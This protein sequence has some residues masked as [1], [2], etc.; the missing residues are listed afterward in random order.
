[1]SLTDRLPLLFLLAWTGLASTG[2]AQDCVDYGGYFPDPAP[3]V[4]GVDTPESALGMA[5]SGSL[6]FVACGAAGLQVIDLSDPGS[7]QV[8]GA[9]GTPGTAHAVAVLEQHAYVADGEAGLQV[10]DISQPTDPVLV[11]SFDTPGNA[12]GIALI[13]SS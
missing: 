10:I 4:A 13:G 7:P 5:A 12:R 11:G 8:V 6:V 3:L 1:M 2:S 9:V